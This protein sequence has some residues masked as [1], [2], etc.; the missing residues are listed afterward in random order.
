MGPVPAGDAASK[1]NPSGP[2]L[3]AC[4]FSWVSTYNLRMSYV[5]PPNNDIAKIANQ[6]Q[7]EQVRKDL[8]DTDLRLQLE[9]FR[10]VNERRGPVKGWGR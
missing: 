7:P 8:F 5:L 9:D 6:D 1:G 2:F 3:F 10:S 4:V